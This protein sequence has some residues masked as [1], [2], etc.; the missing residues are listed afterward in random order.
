MKSLVISA[1]AAMALSTGV[2]ADEISE[3]KSQL[4]ILSERLSTLEENGK[5]QVEQTEALTGELINIQNAT[6]FS[7]IDMTKTEAGLGAAASKVYYSKNPL[8]IG[9]YG[10]MFYTHQRNTGTDETEV[11]RFV[12]YIGYKFSDNIILNSEIEFEHGGQEIAVEQLYLD[13][14]VDPSFNIRLGHQVVPMGLVNLNHEPVL[15]NTVARPDVERYLIP[16]TWHETGVSVYGK[17]DSFNYSA[18]AIVAL[19]MGLANH[20]GQPEAGTFGKNWIRDARRGGNGSNS[21]TSN[22]GIVA[23]LDYTGLNGLLLGASVYTGKAGPSTNGLEEGRMTIA[24]VHAQYQSDGFKIK[25]LYTQSHL[26]HADSYLGDHQGVI[27]TEHAESARGGYINMEYNV[28]PFFASSNTRLPIFFQYENY[29]LATSI[30][31]GTSF[32]NTES[33]TYGLNYFPH[34][35]VV[36]KGEYKLRHNKNGVDTN[37]NEGIYSFGLGFI[38]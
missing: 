13:F 25:G 3:L 1:V 14:L 4:K 27:A 37:D 22:L 9:G 32:G 35:Q 33:F 34:E 11:Y 21:E 28:L 12:P 7:S 20:D 15:F 23:R 17:T 29:N 31:D 19:D 5:K 10:E 36:L 8:S 38:F 24:D 26:S 2:S 30:T 18:G 16:S 6:S